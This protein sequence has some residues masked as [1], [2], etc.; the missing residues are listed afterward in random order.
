[1]TGVKPKNRGSFGLSQSGRNRVEKARIPDLIGT[2]P[3][4]VATRGDAGTHA[5]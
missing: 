4:V 5:S 3:R 1:M 2:E